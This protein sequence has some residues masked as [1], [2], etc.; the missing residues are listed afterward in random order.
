VNEANCN[1]SDCKT[2]YNANLFV[3]NPVRVGLEIFRHHDGEQYGGTG[4]CQL[5]EEE[6]YS[7][8]GR[9]DNFLVDIDH[10]LRTTG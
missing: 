2:C 8:E 9:D 10:R 7:V 6:D 4:G 3:T 1:E 5:G